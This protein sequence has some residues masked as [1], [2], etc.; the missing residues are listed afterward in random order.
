LKSPKTEAKKL[1]H[2][3]QLSCYMIE[4]CREAKI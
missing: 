3:R 4:H 2:A 1:S